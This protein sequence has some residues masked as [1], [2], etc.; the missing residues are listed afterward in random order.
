MNIYRES[1]SRNGL[2]KEQIRRTLWQGLE[3]RKLNKVLMISPDFT[4]LHSNGGFITNACYHFLRAQG[5]Q[6]EVLIAQGTHEDISEEQFREMYGDIPYD[7]MIPHRWREDTVVIGEVPEEYLKE[8]TGG[9]WTQSL[10]VEV[11]RKVLDPS[12]DLILSVGQVVP[13]EVIGMAN[14]SKNIF[15]GVGGRQIINKSHMLG[16]VLGLEQIMGK[17]HSPVRQA[18]DYALKHFLKE[19]PLVF[20]LTVTTADGEEICTHGLYI[21]DERAVLEEAIAKSQEKN[22]RFLDKEIQKCVVYL[23]PREFQSTWVGNKAVYRTRMAMAD[24]GELLILAPGVHCFGEDKTNDEIIRRYGYCGRKRVLELFEREELLKE[25][26]GA[27][28]HLIHG[29]SDGRF[30]VTYA[31]KEISKEEIESVYF[32]AVDYDEA[33]RRYDVSRLKEGGNRMED[34][35]EIY[36]VR[37]PALGLWAAKKA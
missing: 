9:L 37:N 15:V 26:M 12:Y 30:T 4:R 11:N 1:Q 10:A 7:M 33:V 34:G 21:G 16:A 17:D 5:C 3:G 6:V 23:D 27:A 28:A 24:G 20:V 13:H 32:Q 8:I 2:T 18:F 29:S 35:E 31:V 14:H 25:N 19:V 36:F 22:I